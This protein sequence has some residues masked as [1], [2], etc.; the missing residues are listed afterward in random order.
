MGKAKAVIDK[1]IEIDHGGIEEL[2]KYQ[3]DPDPLVANYA[4]ILL[5]G[6]TSDGVESSEDAQKRAQAIRQL[7]RKMEQ[8]A[9][10]KREQEFYSNVKTRSYNKKTIKYDLAITGEVG[11]A[12]DFTNALRD[13]CKVSQ[14]PR[15]V[16]LFNSQHKTL[17][18]S[19]ILQAINGKKTPWYFTTDG[20]FDVFHQVVT[21]YMLDCGWFIEFP[22]LLLH[23][24]GIPMLRLDIVK[25]ILANWNWL[26]AVYT[27]EVFEGFAERYGSISLKE[28]AIEEDIV[29]RKY[30]EEYIRLKIRVWES[31]MNE[32][33]DE[34]ITNKERHPWFEKNQ[35]EFGD[36]IGFTTQ[37]LS[38]EQGF[39]D[40]DMDSKNG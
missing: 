32:S 11:A 2:C 1:M 40:K 15:V 21:R 5:K 19:Q 27:W 31:Q 30:I 37:E 36:K 26:S 4:D 34:I 10:A 20:D 28:S 12:D 35:V 7:A 9:K 13:Y 39:G 24:A 22:A 33:I 17:K 14:N 38:C 3:K 25:Y 18:V 6:F 29:R 8:Q 23:T 16:K